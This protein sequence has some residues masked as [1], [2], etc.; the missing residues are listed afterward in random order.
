[1]QSPFSP[2]ATDLEVQSA[3]CCMSVA[4][5]RLT[6]NES[7]FRCL[8]FYYHDCID[9]KGESWRLILKLINGFCGVCVCQKQ[10]DFLWLLEKAVRFGKV[11]LVLVD[12]LISIQPLPCFVRYATL[13]RD[14]LLSNATT[15]DCFF[16][17]SPF[18]VIRHRRWH[19][20]KLANCF[21]NGLAA[22]ARSPIGRAPRA[23]P[24]VRR[25]RALP[26]SRLQRP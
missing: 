17:L 5:T 23:V 12:T 6:S 7:Y 20:L 15:S 21:E 4:A 26:P 13:S 14:S 9:L 3:T 16:S 8:T 25:R 10:M 24:C 18:T 2:P 1:M 22:S 19:Q 11:I